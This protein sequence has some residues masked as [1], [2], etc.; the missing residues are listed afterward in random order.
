MIILRLAPRLCPPCLD[1]HRFLEGL[2]RL[3]R[4]V[5]E[6]PRQH[7]IPLYTGSKLR[8]LSAL[9][10]Q[11]WVP[12]TLDVAAPH[13]LNHF[14]LFENWNI[15]SL[16]RPSSWTTTNPVRVNF[17]SCCPLLKIITFGGTENTGMISDLLQTYLQGLESCRLAVHS[18]DMS[19]TLGLIG[20]LDTLTSITIMDKLQDSE[21]MPGSI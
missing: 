15:T 16:G 8:Y 18:L 7:T 14:P 4:C 10:A 6:D 19:T 12:D 11:A 13:L 21:P 1:H 20:L 2:C 5:L 3:F 17:S 9:F